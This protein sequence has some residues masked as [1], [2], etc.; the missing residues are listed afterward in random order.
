MRMLTKTTIIA[1]VLGTMLA[2]GAIATG[3][4]V[5]KKSQ[6]EDIYFGDPNSFVSNNDTAVSEGPVNPTT[7]VVN[8]TDTL[9]NTTGIIPDI[10]STNPNSSFT[11]NT[12]VPIWWDGFDGDSINKDFWTVVD[13]TGK[14][15]WGNKELQT[16]SKDNVDVYDGMM[17]ISALRGEDGKWTSGRVMSKGGWC[18][19]M[20]LPNKKVASKIYFES[21][22]RI[23]EAGNG[24]WPGFWA[25]PKDSVYGKFSQSGEIDMMELRDKFE[26]LTQGIHFGGEEPD[27]LKNMT[28]TGGG[29]NYTFA[30]G[31]FIIG[32]EWTL[33]TIIFYINNVETSRRHSKA[34]DTD[35]GWYTESDQARSIASPFDEPFQVIFNIAVGGNFPQYKPDETT[36]DAV[37]MS[38]NYF[39]VFADFEDVA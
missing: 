27:N 31:T 33:D 10:P 22:V 14:T 19:G 39:R 21:M 9:V 8:Q 3:V 20:I 7:I 32:I 38:V 5:S 4:I 6:P 37:V 17:H 28:R 16:Y 23:P 12:R 24:L 34:I 25:F 11:N 1:I 29:A 26:R 15:G 13:G 18:P 35:G 2:G 36:P 30:D